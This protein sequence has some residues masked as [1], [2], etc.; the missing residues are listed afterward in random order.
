MLDAAMRKKP[1]S[2]LNCCVFSPT[3]R[4]RDSECGGVVDALFDWSPVSHGSMVCLKSKWVHLTVCLKVWR[5]CKKKLHSSDLVHLCSCV[6]CSWKRKVCVSVCGRECVQAWEGVK[7]RHAPEWQMNKKSGA[8]KAQR[9]SA[10]ETGVCACMR[11]SK[12]LKFIENISP[13]QIAQCNHYI[14]EY[15]L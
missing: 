9:H 4:E 10:W 7:H 12:H 15:K 5:R 11:V 3:E 2:L 13:Y 6:V 8:G 14:A 1:C